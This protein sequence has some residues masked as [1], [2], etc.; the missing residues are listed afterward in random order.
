[1][2]VP[3]GTIIVNADEGTTRI[4][5]SGI[6]LMMESDQFYIYPLGNNLYFEGDNGGGMR[7]NSMNNT[8]YTGTVSAS[9]LTGA[10]VWQQGHR[11]PNVWYGTTPPDSS[12]GQDGD[13]YI[14][15]S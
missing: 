4:T 13:I 14:M 5:P 12:I 10:E 9:L 8:L 7:L 1:M 2:R 3:F 6:D 11:V 15:Y